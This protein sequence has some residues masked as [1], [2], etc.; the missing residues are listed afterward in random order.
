[1]QSS[2]IEDVIDLAEPRTVARMI[3]VS[4]EGKS[5][6]GM[7]SRRFAK[8][9]RALILSSRSWQIGIKIIAI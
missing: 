2:G 8:S 7:L 4:S 9:E 3:E 5:R 6:S 1:M